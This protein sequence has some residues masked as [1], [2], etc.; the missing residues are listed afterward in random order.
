MAGMDE[1]RQ[2][3]EEYDEHD[4]P[5]RKI[6]ETNSRDLQAD[7]SGNLQSVNEKSFRREIRY[8]YKYYSHGN[9]TERVI[10]VRYETNPDFQRSNIERREIV[11]YP[12]PAA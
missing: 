4:N 7:E 2:T 10:S 12:K 5:I 6:D 11:Y 1:N 3:W 8:Q 9:W